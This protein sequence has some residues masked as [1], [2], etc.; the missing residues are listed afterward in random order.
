MFPSLVEHALLQMLWQVIFNDEG[1]FD[2]A[3][4]PSVCSCGLGQRKPLLNWT[5]LTCITVAMAVVLC[6]LH[7][8]D[9]VC[10]G[11][12][13]LGLVWGNLLHALVLPVNVLPLG[14]GRLVFAFV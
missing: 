8:I 6:L 12:N 13:V 10:H 2:N 4:R 14:H 3:L 9:L 1:A 7:G 11:L 5:T